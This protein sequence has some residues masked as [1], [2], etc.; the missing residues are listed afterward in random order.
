MGDYIAIRYR[1]K[2]K[3]EFMRGVS[4]ANYRTNGTEI[5]SWS[6]A[7]LKFDDPVARKTWEEFL[8]HPISRVWPDSDLM[9]FN[10]QDWPLIARYYSWLTGT[11]K[12]T[13][14]MKVIPG[15]IAMI[16]KVLPLIA[17]EWKVE[18][19]IRDLLYSCAIDPVCVS[20][21][22]VYSHQGDDLFAD[23]KKNGPQEDSMYSGFGS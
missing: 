8:N 3:P 12:G 17:V 21:V 13:Q 11:M 14:C 2:I 16:A 23:R 10:P 18:V 20:T 22:D 6:R 9:H 4:E 15:G 7:G 19:D 1:V 5:L